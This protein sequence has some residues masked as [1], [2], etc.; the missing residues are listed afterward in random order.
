MVLKKPEDLPLER[1]QV[2]NVFAGIMIGLALTLNG[3][4]TE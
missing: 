2:Q 1:N 4:L 3:R